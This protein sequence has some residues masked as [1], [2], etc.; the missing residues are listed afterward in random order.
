L[1]KVKKYKFAASIE[2]EYQTPQGSDV[3]AEIKKCVEY[4]KRA[5]A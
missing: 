3:L 2:Y 4:C 1:M 5:L